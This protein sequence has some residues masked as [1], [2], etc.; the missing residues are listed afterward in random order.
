MKSTASPTV[1]HGLAVGDLDAELIFQLHDQL[2][3]VQA[4]RVQILLKDASGV[5]A[6]SGTPNCSTRMARTLAKMSSLPIKALCV[7]LPPVRPNS[8]HCSNS[9]DSGRAVHLYTTP[10]YSRVT[11]Y[12]QTPLVPSLPSDTAGVSSASNSAGRLA[13]RPLRTARAPAQ[14]VGDGPP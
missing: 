5:T 14:G 11:P 12:P 4:V 8:F 10:G 7:E 13:T 2:H 3:Q 9:G 1:K 6:S